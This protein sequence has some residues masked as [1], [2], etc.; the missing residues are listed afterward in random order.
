MEGI[1]AG[2]VRQTAKGKPFNVGVQQMQ[3]RGDK[4]L[5]RESLEPWA[6]ARTGGPLNRVQGVLVFF[7]TMEGIGGF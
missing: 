1:I 2:R 6:M 7:R 3:S 4:Y 5:S